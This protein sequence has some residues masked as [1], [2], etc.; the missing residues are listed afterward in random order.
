MD[1]D[2]VKKLMILNVAIGQFLFAILPAV[3]FA[4]CAVGQC[5]GLPVFFVPGKDGIHPCIL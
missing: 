2:I 1:V 5:P 3:W 4:R